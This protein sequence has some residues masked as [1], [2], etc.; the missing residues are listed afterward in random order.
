MKKE[1][2]LK[3]THVIGVIFTVLVAVIMIIYCI[4]LLFPLVWLIINSFKGYM[5]YYTVSSFAFPQQLNFENYANVFDKLIYTVIKDGGRLTYDI[6]DMFFYSAYNAGL[7][8][9]YSVVTIVFTA[10]VI[11]RFKDFWLCKLLFSIGLIWML[12]PAV[13]DGGAG[14]L[15]RKRLGLY[16]NLTLWILFSGGCIFTGQWFFVTVGYFRNLGK[17]YAD[18]AYIDGAG[19]MTILWHIMLPIAYPMMILIFFISFTGSWN[20]Y[21][22]FLYYMPSYANLALGIYNFQFNAGLMGATV[23]EVLAG[24]V[25]VCVPVVILYLVTHKFIISNMNIGGLK[26]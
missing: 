22:I 16:D 3:A 24:F 12:L 5:E 10:Y 20:D 4:S 18:A 21:G 14:L 15:F 13:S 7:T 23:P 11:G 19:E 8:A 6:F 17:E 9:L 2:S 1:N 26:G 25:I